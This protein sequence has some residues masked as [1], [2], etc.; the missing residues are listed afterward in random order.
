MYVVSLVAN[1]VY[2]VST[3]IPMRSE[4]SREKQASPTKK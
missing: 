1:K 4:A 2:G 3:H